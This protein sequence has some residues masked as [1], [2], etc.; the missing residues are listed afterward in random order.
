MAERDRDAEQ[1]AQLRLMD[2]IDGPVGAI[3]ADGERFQ[4]NV[5]QPDSGKHFC[6]DASRTQL[7]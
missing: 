5:A 1:V 6:S 4:Q 3:M 2:K 7:P